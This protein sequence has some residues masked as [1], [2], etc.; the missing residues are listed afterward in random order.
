VEQAA[1]PLQVG[2]RV[3]AVVTGFARYGVFVAT[4]D[5]R[6]GL[7]HISEIADWFVQDARAYFRMGDEVL[8]EVIDRQD[9]TGRYAFSTRRVGGPAAALSTP[10]HPQ[11]PDALSTSRP[12]SSQGDLDELVRYITARIG[13]VTGEA[14]DELARLVSRHGAVRVALAVGD[15]TRRFDHATAFVQWV[16][17]RLDGP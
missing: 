13:E 10:A 12:A 2:D 3:P 17:R 14:Y 7:I 11:L 4:R 1:G 9:E 5:G 15:V 16:G 6:R 8:V